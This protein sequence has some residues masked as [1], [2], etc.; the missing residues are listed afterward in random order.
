M[1]C[2]FRGRHR[3]RGVKASQRRG[4]GPDVASQQAARI[5]SSKR[6]IFEDH[7]PRYEKPGPG[8]ISTGGTEKNKYAYTS[9]ALKSQ[10][11]Y[12][13]LKRVSVEDPFSR[14]KISRE[15]R[16]KTH[17]SHFSSRL[18]RLPRQNAFLLNVDIDFAIILLRTKRRQA[19]I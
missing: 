4:A 7:R 2:D 16:R 10:T 9:D 8:V 15:K 19:F 1:A 12:W 17:F 18:G 5:P 3:P 14:L 11:E 6:T 13:L